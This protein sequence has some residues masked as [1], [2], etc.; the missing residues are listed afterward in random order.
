MTTTQ[1]FVA[2]KWFSRGYDGTNTYKIDAD[3][4]KRAI[5]LRTSGD[6]EDCDEW[7]ERIEELCGGDNDLPYSA[8]TMLSEL[9]RSGWSF[10][11]DVTYNYDDVATEN[12]LG[13]ETEE[14]L[15][16]IGTTKKAAK[17]A[18]TKLLAGELNEGGWE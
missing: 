12:G 8:M 2:E 10:N 4:I 14:Q 16:G 15:Y 7:L 1:L 18:L 17:A 3:L 5:E 9:A 6:E 13:I 11:P